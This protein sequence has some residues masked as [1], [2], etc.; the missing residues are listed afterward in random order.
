MSSLRARPS[1]GSLGGLRW[2]QIQTIETT[3]LL[4]NAR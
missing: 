4:E 2:L 1:L 3:N